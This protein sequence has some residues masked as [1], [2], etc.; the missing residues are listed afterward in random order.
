[1]MVGERRRGSGTRYLGDNRPLGARS[2]WQIDRVLGPQQLAPTAYSIDLHRRSSLVWATDSPGGSKRPLT[3]KS[4]CY[5]PIDILG[6]VQ[7]VLMRDPGR[8]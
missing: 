7:E 2:I 4:S 5:L 3:Q 1:M 6:K 8:L